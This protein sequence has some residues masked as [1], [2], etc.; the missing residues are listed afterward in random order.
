[1]SKFSQ[2]TVVFKF[3]SAFFAVGCIIVHTI[4][5]IYGGGMV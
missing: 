2:M 1:M 5:A 3:L 4:V